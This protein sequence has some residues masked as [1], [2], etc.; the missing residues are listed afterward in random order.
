ME[1]NKKTIDIFWTGGMDSTFRVIQLLVE[2][3]SKVRP[4]YIVRHEHSTGIEIDTMIGIRR[5]I[6]RKFPEVRSRFLPTKYTNEGCIRVFEEIDDE[7]EELRK[8]VR[9]HEQYQI[10]AHYCREFNINQIDL[11]YEGSLNPIFQGDKKVSFYF[12]NSLAFQS[13]NRVLGKMS[14][15]ACYDYAKEKGWDDILLMTTFCRRPRKRITPCGQCGPCI[16]VASR[17]MGFRLPLKSRIK[18]NI[19]F[20]L[21][22]FYRR[23]YLNHDKWLFKLI[24]KKFENKL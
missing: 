2:T 24:K 19:I 4:H 8:T 15:R 1:D 21:R 23:N 7:I 11:C 16:D 13:F 20:P 3:S 5:E 9:V 22:K 12:G 18:A 14:K 17:G 10:L 6:V